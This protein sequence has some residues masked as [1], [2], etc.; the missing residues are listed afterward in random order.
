MLNLWH[1]VLRKQKHSG[2]KLWLIATDQTNRLH[3]VTCHCH[4]CKNRM[5]HWD[6]VLLR[7][8]GGRVKTYFFHSFQHCLVSQER[9]LLFQVFTAL[10]ISRKILHEWKRL[11]HC[12]EKGG[13]RGF[14]RSRKEVNQER[15]ISTKTLQNM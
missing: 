1:V 12:G 10:Q 11:C 7:R 6:S 8:C 14:E 3:Y 4:G 9:P 15:R 13:L 2:A 5:K